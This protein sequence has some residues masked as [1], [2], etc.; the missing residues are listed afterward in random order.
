MYF[1]NIYHQFLI[2]T[3]YF[4]RIIKEKN[5]RYKSV[6]IIFALDILY[7]NIYKKLFHYFELILKS[8]RIFYSFLFDKLYKN[9][10]LKFN[11][12]SNIKIDLTPLTCHLMHKAL[13]RIALKINQSTNQFSKNKISNKHGFLNN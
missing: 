7:L 11:K 10:H 4:F 12:I 2:S 3:I 6:D 5:I 8:V 1:L 13:I 9:I